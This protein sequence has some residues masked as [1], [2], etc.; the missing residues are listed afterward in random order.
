MSGLAI[1][2][3]AGVVTAGALGF[4]AYQVMDGIGERNPDG[5]DADKA[6]WVG[7]GLI[8]LGVASAVGGFFVGGRGFNTSQL[9]AALIGGGAGAIVGG[10]GAGM[11]F[12]SKH[13]IG[14]ETQVNDLFASYNRDFDDELDLDTTWR[15]PEDVRRVEHRHEDSEGRYQYSTYTYYNIQKLA[16]EADTNHDAKVTRDELRIAVA[17]FDVDGNGRL[18]PDENRRFDR[19]SGERAWY[20]HWF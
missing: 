15:T 6:R 12:T 4:G 13:G 16:G 14:V 1:G 8:G 5:S 10:I 9:G 3:G 2:I 19:E 11:G 20:G 17:R 18:Q 7:Y